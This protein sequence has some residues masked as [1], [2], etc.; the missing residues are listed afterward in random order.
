MAY[1]TLRMNGKQFVLVPKT[2]FRR[3]TAEDRRDGRKVQRALARFRS[4]KLKTISHED[5]MRELGL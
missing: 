1:A 5:L 2:E 3:L 4:G